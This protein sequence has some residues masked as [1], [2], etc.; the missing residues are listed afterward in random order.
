MA[1]SDV[2]S[3]EDALKAFLEYLVDPMLPAKLSPSYNPT[4]SQQQSVAKQVHSVVLLYNYYHR[5]Q[6]PELAFLSSDEFCKLAVALRPALSVHTKFT[7]KPDETELVD[8]K[9]L[10]ITADK[11]LNACNICKCLDTSKNVPDVEGWPVSKVVVLLIDNKKENCF[12]I[13]SS[14]TEGVWSLVEKDVETICQSSEITT[15]DKPTSKK[16]RVI[17]KSTKNELN[18]EEDGMLQF[19]YSA[20]KE[21]AGIDE[22]DITILEGRTVYSQS[23]IK[24]ASRFYIMKCSQLIKREF[25]QVPIK[26]LVESLQGP[27]V[28][29]SSSCWTVTSV[30]EYFHVLPYS[31]IISEWISRETFSS[32]LR[33][34]KLTEKNMIVGHPEMTESC[35]SSEGMSNGLDLKSSSDAIEALNQNENN[36]SCGVT[37]SA[38][39]KEAQDAYV[40]NSL[41]SPS[42]MK[43]GCQHIA[44]TLQVRKDKAIENPSVQHYSNQ[45]K[46]PTQ[47][48]N[49]DAIR[50]LITEGGTKNQSSCDKGFSK[51]S[52]GNDSIEESALITNNPNSNIEKLQNLI[53]SKGKTLSQT[54]KA[55]FENDSIENCA[56]IKRS[57]KSHLEK[58]QIIAS[59]GMTLSQ[60]AKSSF[61]N[62]HI[63][64]CALTANNPNTGLEKLQFLVASK[65][66]A[67]SQTALNALKRKRNA[68]ALQQRKIEDELALCDKKIQRMLTSGEDELELKI[69]SIIEGCNDAFVRNQGRISQNLEDQSLSR[70]IQQ[71]RLTEAVLIMQSPFIFVIFVVFDCVDLRAEFVELGWELDFEEKVLNNELDGICHENSW[72]LPIY[73]VSEL[74]GGFQAD[75]AVKGL[76]FE[77]SCGGNLCSHPHEARESAAAQM[78]ARLRSRAKSATTSGLLLHRQYMDS[79]GGIHSS[80]L[81]NHLELLAF[82]PH[83]RE[84]EKTF[85]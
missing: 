35:T 48:K 29:K 52:F 17:K 83:Y 45:S 69:E 42:Q 75:V 82:D 16:K 46:N 4:L 12:L 64:E 63:E 34:S 1:S 14:I 73:R 81:M 43:E 84:R 22:T 44:N 49:G 19:G 18:F 9:Q 62:D 74:D 8:V 32:S 40:D 54:A 30:V 65:G 3:T 76:D 31:E 59:K 58:L 7:Q 38:S 57:P 28:K 21:T 10:P 61:Q 11:I 56:L 55:S 66:E 6:Y 2:C 36:G 51:T 67:L 5:K 27:L 60:T 71:R 24:T 25:I 79:P 50:M 26:Y 33:D 85:Q 70:P 15:G 77:C 68:L 20:V 80:R 41:A 37:C 13:F 39:I 78:L 53:A 47:A 72:L 23:K